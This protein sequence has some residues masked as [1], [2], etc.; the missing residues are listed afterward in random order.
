DFQARSIIDED[1]LRPLTFQLSER[2][3]NEENSYD[4]LFESKRQIYTTTS[5]K[6]DEDEVTATTRF[7]FDFGQDVLSSAFYLRS[8]PL[9]DGDEITMLVTP[10][11]RPYLA[12]FK[13]TGREARKIDGKTYEAIKIDAQIGKVN[14]D[15]SLKHYEKIKKTTLWLTDDSYR[16][17]I[18]LQSQ[19][20]LGF[21]SGRLDSL[22][23]LE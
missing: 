9:R 2:E 7:R 5:K 8:Q 11:N 19:I 23:W 6:K 16:I 20:S 12:E 13:V 4:I 18:E 14:R 15:L 3:R 21:L 10:F 22:K 1:S 17:P